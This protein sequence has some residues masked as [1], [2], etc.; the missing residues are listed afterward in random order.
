LKKANEVCLLRRIRM[1]AK[2]MERY[3]AF[4]GEAYGK[5]QGVMPQEYIDLD[6]AEISFKAGIRAT[7]GYFSKHW[8]GAARG[9]LLYEISDKDRMLLEDG[10]LPPDVI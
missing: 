3:V 8:M 1:E 2:D 7:V 9:M 6:I 5:N 4:V 10:I